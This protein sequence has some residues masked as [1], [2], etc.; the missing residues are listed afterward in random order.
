MTIEVITI[1]DLRRAGYCVSGVRRW[2]NKDP[3]ISLRKLIEDGIEVTEEIRQKY[4]EVIHA[5][6]MTRRANNGRS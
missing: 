4:P 6:E 3:N 2:C 5:V 1:T